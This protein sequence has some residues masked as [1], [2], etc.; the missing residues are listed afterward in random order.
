M[1]ETHMFIPLMEIELSTLSA[2]KK[3]P[4]DLRTPDKYL[5]QGEIK[6]FKGQILLVP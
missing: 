6:V 5:Y 4:F 1:F 2:F 3:V